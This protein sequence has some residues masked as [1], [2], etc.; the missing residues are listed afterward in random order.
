[1]KLERFAWERALCDLT[2]IKDKTELVRE[3]KYPRRICLKQGE[4]VNLMIKNRGNY[5]NH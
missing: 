1:M 5:S 2:K 4:V 3:G